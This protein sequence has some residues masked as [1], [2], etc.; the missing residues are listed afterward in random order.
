MAASE[1]SSADGAKPL[2]PVHV[3]VMPGGAISFGVELTGTGEYV[4]PDLAVDGATAAAALESA[5]A[6]GGGM[7]RPS[8]GAAGGAAEGGCSGGG[9]SS[10]SSGGGASGQPGAAAGR[11]EAEAEPPDAG[12]DGIL[13]SRFRMF[14]SGERARSGSLEPPGGGGAPG[15]AADSGTADLDGPAAAAS[16]AAAEPGAAADSG[17]AGVVAAAETAGRPPV[18]R[19]RSARA[20]WLARTSS[21]LMYGDLGSLEVGAYEKWKT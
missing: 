14:G 2:A 18:L 5:A 13:I 3:I 9:G 7:R 20:Q 17:V 4:S 6:C 12:G 15:G 11:G 8:G 21:R 16:G 10:S 19:A 1:E